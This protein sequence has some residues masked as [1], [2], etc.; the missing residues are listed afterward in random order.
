MAL[1]LN[2]RGYAHARRCIE[3]ERVV[4]DVMDDWSEHQPSAEE[5]NRFIAEHGGASTGGGTWA[6]TTRPLLRPR[7]RYGFPYG[8]FEAV[9]RCGTIAAEV[10]AAQRKY[11]DIHSAAAHLHAMLEALKVEPGDGP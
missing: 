6:S 10:R 4:L 11:D 2:R 8:D 1:R 7:G 5:E 9:H 3:A